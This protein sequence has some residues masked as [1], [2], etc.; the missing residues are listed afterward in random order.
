MKI[1]LR[2]WRQKD[3]DATGRFVTYQVD[4]VTPDMSFLEMMDVVLN[5]EPDRPQR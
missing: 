4:E 2:I 1:T 5:G 3:A